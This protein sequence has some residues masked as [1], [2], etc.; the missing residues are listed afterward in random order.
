MPTVRSIDIKEYFVS[1]VTSGRLNEDY[2]L[3]EDYVSPFHEYEDCDDRCDD[4][5]FDDDVDAGFDDDEYPEDFTPKKGEDYG[6]TTRVI[7]VT[8]EEYGLSKAKRPLNS[9]LD[10]SKLVEA[11]FTP[12]PDWQD[13]VRRY[14]EKA[15]L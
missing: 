8:T 15:K 9:R 2:T 1:L 11:G 5:S 7:P 10:R 13:A 3:N 6:L 14:L 12:L 4:D